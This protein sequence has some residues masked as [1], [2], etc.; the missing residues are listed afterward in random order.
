MGLYGKEE[1]E[2]ERSGGVGSQKKEKKKEKNGFK[3][4]AFR[5]CS[6]F[7]GRQDGVQ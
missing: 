6:V 4:P 2:E 7:N 1:E 5:Q 3:Y